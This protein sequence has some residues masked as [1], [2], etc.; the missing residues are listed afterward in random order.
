M[1][2]LLGLQNIL[3]T[4]KRYFS[5]ITLQSYSIHVY[6]TRL[7]SVYPSLLVR[8]F[9][10]LHPRPQ[11]LSSTTPPRR[12]SVTVVKNAATGQRT[13]NL[14]AAV[15]H[16]E[17]EEE[18]DEDTD[19]QTEAREGRKSRE[20]K[21]VIEEPDVSM[22]S[23]TAELERGRREG[24]GEWGRREG[25]GERRG[26]GRAASWL[27]K[28]ATRYSYVVHVTHTEKYVVM[29]GLLIIKYCISPASRRQQKQRLSNQNH[30]HHPLTLLLKSKKLCQRNRF[31]HS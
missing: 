29:V 7:R 6:L 5:P 13:N 20:Y 14:I 16:E 9:P 4:F 31:S 21:R 15:W 2:T 3:Y 18:E 23:V 1:P 8:L 12:L 24:E 17:Q 30:T 25:E 27:R 28:I 19:S 22:S 10:S 26:F 11:F